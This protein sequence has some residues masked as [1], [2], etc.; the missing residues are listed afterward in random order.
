MGDIMFFNNENIDFEIISVLKLHHE[1]MDGFAYARNFH[2]LSFRVKGNADFEF[3]NK[4]LHA[5]SGD[6][7]YIPAYSDYNVTSTQEDLYVIHFNLKVP[8]TECPEIFSSHDTH[9][10]EQKFDEIFNAWS[11]KEFGY[12]YECK[13]ILYQ[14]LAR[15]IRQNGTRQSDLLSDIIKYIHENYCSKSL[16]ISHI[17]A[18]ANVSDTYFRKLFY[19]RFN[20]T[21]RKYINDLRISHALEL[22]SSGYFTVS[23]VSEKCGFESQNY[24][25]YAVKKSTGFSPIEYKNKNHIVQK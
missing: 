6:L 11:K 25:S 1:S 20:T 9:Y 15:C 24:F 12:I 13:A 7:I 21:P 14:I 18:V 17:C 2:A 19:N 10:Y 4:N 3:S 23:E 8:Q 5:G 16:T 22:L